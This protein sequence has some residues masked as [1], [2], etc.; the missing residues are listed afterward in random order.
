MEQYIDYL[1]IIFAAIAA[2]LAISGNTWNMDKKYLIKFTFKGWLFIVFIVF[3][4]LISIITTYNNNQDALILKN[5]LD[6]QLEIIKKQKYP[7]PKSLKVDF[8]SSISLTK[9][10]ITQINEIVSKSNI[11]GTSLLFNTNIT[12]DAFKKVTSFKDIMMMM[13]I[14]FSNDNKILT[15]KLKNSSLSIVGYNI[16]LPDNNTFGLINNKTSVIF[17]GYS[18]IAEDIS[19]NY[20]AP[21]LLDF[22]NSKVTISY[23]LLFPTLR[24]VETFPSKLYADNNKNYLL[25]NFK[26]IELRTN[27]YSI[28]ISDFRKI[29]DRKFEGSWMIK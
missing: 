29:D 19:T 9:K 21:S 25:L 14:S 11:K 8:S 7:I 2:I 16:A 26:S 3:G 18:L 24:Y 4:I 5:K 28:K 10:E 13:T 22:I 27:S 17:D 20:I 23:I 15:I 12:N 1:G 6:T